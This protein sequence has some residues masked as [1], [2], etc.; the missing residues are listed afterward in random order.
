MGEGA[1]NASPS[2]EYIRMPPNEPSGSVSRRATGTDPRCP[3]RP[4]IGSPIAS[5]SVEPASRVISLG[6][7]AR[8]AWA[9]AAM[10]WPSGA[11]TAMPPEFRD[12]SQP[13]SAA[14]R[15]SAEGWDRRSSST[16]SASL[17]RFSTSCAVYSDSS[18]TICSAAFS[19]SRYV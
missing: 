1:G 15:D 2:M 5:T 7:P 18:L 8:L 19:R 3:L 11:M 16:R 14:V 17:N 13:V 12:G 10:T 6:Q 4:R 9:E